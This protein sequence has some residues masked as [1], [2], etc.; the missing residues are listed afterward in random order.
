M[1]LTY[2]MALF[3]VFLVGFLL[4]A[5]I[6]SWLN[7]HR[8]HQVDQ[9]ARQLA[10]QNQA[11]FAALSMQALEKASSQFLRLAN[12]TLSKQ[13]ELNAHELEG[14]KALIDQTLQ[15]GE[16]GLLFLGLLHNPAV[17]LPEDIDVRYPL[18]RPL[19]TSHKRNK[20]DG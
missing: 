16:T 10:S 8:Q 19:T 14:K 18:N 4:G 6:I 3:A 2:L 9:F 13:S 17:L 20:Q 5:L 7:H 12:E 15:A 1:D 11:E